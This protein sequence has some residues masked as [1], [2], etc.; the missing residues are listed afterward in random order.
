MAAEKATEAL[1]VAM[2]SGR[3]VAEAAASAGISPRTAYRRLN[4]VDIR[5]CIREARTDL[6]EQAVGRLADAAT[7]AVETLVEN[8]AA[9]SETVRV[10]AAV[11][12]LDQ[13]AKL[14]AAT[15]TDARL[16]ALEAALAIQEP[17]RG[18]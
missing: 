5:W 14:R 13:L 6:L 8:L 16:T 12:L 11:A 4:D 1:I 9:P 18:R 10:R 17:R 3:T 7:A 2:A 15:E